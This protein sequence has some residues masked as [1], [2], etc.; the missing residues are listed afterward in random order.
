MVG[1]IMCHSSQI[2]SYWNPKTKEYS[3]DKSFEHIKSS[4]QGYDLVLGNLETTIPVNQQDYSGYPRFGAPPALVKGL[5]NSGFHILSTANNHSAD[6]G[7]SAIDHTISTVFKEGLIPIGTYSSPEDYENRRNLF[8]EKNGIKIAIYNYTYSTNGIKVPGNKIVRLLDEKLIQADIEFAKSQNSDFIIVWYHF[9][10]EY[11]AEPDQNQ[12]KWAEFALNSGADL[13]LGGHPHVVQRYEKLYR[14]EG[15]IFPQEQLI[16]YSLGNFLS[17]QK[18]PFTDGGIIFY[19]DLILEEKKRKRI[20]NVS[21]E[22]VWVNPETYA[23]VPIEKYFNQD[24]NLKLPSKSE[25][26]MKLYHEQLLKVMEKS[27]N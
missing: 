8:L 23:V 11:G 15:D 27:K 13:V 18:E 14:P 22:A 3:A 25:K 19:F 5:A 2:T 10:T 24:L 12:K 26:K 4:L 21:Y 6:K 16:V 9:G 7:S 20:A 17:A 1:D